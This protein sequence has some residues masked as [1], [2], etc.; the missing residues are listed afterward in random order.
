MVGYTVGLAR[1]GYH[2]EFFDHIS[3]IQLFAAVGFRKLYGK[4][5]GQNVC[6]LRVCSSQG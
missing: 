3:T 1:G 6:S 2:D 4:R 5:I